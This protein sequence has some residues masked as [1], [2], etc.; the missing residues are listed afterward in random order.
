MLHVRNAAH[1]P[2]TVPPGEC[3]DF[4]TASYR[5]RQ[6]QQH[7]LDQR[8]M[9]LMSIGKVENATVNV[10]VIRAYLQRNIAY[11][12][13]NIPL[14]IRL[15]EETLITPTFTVAFSTLPIDI[16]FICL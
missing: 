12:G 5:P 9:K 8:Q 2:W 15:E 11:G 10:G 6:L 13:S 1:F 3:H 4:C 7:T 14:Q 16:S